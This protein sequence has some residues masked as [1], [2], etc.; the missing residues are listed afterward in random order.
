MTIALVNV[1]SH[2]LDLC[3]I[4]RRMGD[5]MKPLA[6]LAPIVAGLSRACPNV[7]GLIE[8]RTK[9]RRRRTN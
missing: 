7:L 4:A 2:S 5:S 3:R 6:R 9:R 1:H 8:M